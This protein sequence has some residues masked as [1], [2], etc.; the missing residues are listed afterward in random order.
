MADVRQVH[1]IEHAE[2]LPKDDD[3]NEH[4]EES[5]AEI[6]AEN[7]EQ[8]GVFSRLANNMI[9]FG[10]LFGRKTAIFCALAIGLFR[11]ITAGAQATEV[12][13]GPMITFTLAAGADWTLPANQDRLTSNVWLTRNITSG[14]FNARTESSYTHFF[15]PADTE[16]AYGSLANY[17]SLTYS[18]WE[19]W[20]NHNP[21]SMVGHP[22]VLH[23]IS[24]DVYLS[25]EFLSWGGASGGFSYERSVSQVP[26]PRLAA[27]L[28]L[29]LAVAVGPWYQR[30][31]R[32][33]SAGLQ[34]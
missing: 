9:L 4:E 31:K 23:L 29:G 15:S 19:A 6:N 11:G 8:F 34:L 7:W 28:V 2:N 10:K 17:S 26:E 14:L 30:R 22:A 3:K 32:G 24:G 20:N 13:N 5:C 12:W 16:W 1:C 33:L 21:P 25:I 27:L 18:N